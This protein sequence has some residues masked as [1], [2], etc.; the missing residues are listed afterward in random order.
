MKK[1]LVCVNCPKGCRITVTLEEDKILNIEGNSCPRGKAYATSEMTCPM[2]IL[3][4]TVK[5]IGASQNVLPVYT[6]K[7]IPLSKFTEAMEEIR[8]IN[9]QAPITI[10]QVIKKDLAHT[11]VDLISSRS[12]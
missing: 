5:I 9:V 11:G 4:S 7:E 6:E 10:G 1:E 12:M 8:K 2:R 3:T